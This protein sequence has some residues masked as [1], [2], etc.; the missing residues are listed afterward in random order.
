MQSPGN[1]KNGRLI[2]LFCAGLLAGALIAIIIQ[3]AYQKNKRPQDD[4]T[5]LIYQTDSLQS[6]F[7]R[8]L[9]A[10]EKYAAVLSNKNLD[11]SGLQILDSL[12]VLIAH[13][14]VNFL[15]YLDSLEKKNTG[16]DK[17]TFNLLTRIID[18]Y[19]DAVYQSTALDTTRNL[20]NIGNT[21]FSFDQNML[22]NMQDELRTREIE[23]INLN[24]LLYANKISIPNKFPLDYKSMIKQQDSVLNNVLVSERR[25]NENLKDYNNKLK[26]DNENLNAALQTLHNSNTQ[27]GVMDAVI[28]S[29]QELNEQVNLAKADCY[30]TRADARQIISNAKQRE[31]LLENALQILNTLSQSG[32]TSIRQQAQ[33]KLKTLKTIAANN[34]D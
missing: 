31:E 16:Y 5:R 22:S 17:N 12:N 1:K 25:R 14:E 33:T 20:F 34:H 19:R 27:S 9:Q 6:R 18:G 13:S 32:N 10:N 29:K 2:I 8:L 21:N 15:T 3:A 4:T 11:S 28:V 23:I 30:M 26:S 7:G 24:N